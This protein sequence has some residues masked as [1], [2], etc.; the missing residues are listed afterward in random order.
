[1]PS[2]AVPIVPVAPCLDLSDGTWSST[3]FTERALGEGLRHVRR[4]SFPCGDVTLAELLALGDVEVAEHLTGA[5]AVL[6]RIEPRMLVLVSVSRGNGELTVAGADRGDVDRVTADL[7]ANLRQEPSADQ[8]EV[9]VGFWAHGAVPPR[10]R[11]RLRA[12]A[13]SEIAGNYAASTGSGLTELMAATEPGPGGL[14]LWHGEPGTGKSHALR[15]LIREWR[16][17]CDAHFIA[18]PE[19]FLGP[20]AGYLLGT[21]LRSSRHGRGQLIILED[22]GELLAADAR[23]VAGQA[24]SRLLNVSDGLLG[25]GLRAVVLVTT[26]EPLRRLHPAVVRPGRCWA[27]V[28]FARLDASAAD[29]WLQARGVDARAG[30][31]MTLAEL[32]AL[33]RG[34]LLDDTAPVGFAPG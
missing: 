13:W 21:L 23:A 28:E 3:A 27:E 26:N 8:D 19:T 32:Y 20:D 25:E 33:A 29:A 9:L 11:R 30:R 14:V 24:L 6:L 18:D 31:A 22:A 1:M 4:G 34:R 5:L 7:V 10:A 2:P 12:P 15:A 17:W 16:R